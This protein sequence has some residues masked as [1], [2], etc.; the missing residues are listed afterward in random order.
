[1]GGKARAQKLTPEQ[2]TESARRAV[3]A[4][5]AKT[6]RLV[7]EINEGSRALLKRSKAA[8]RRLAQR[9]RKTP[10]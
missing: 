2:R 1:M 9:K 5:W 10:R 7:E 4:R 8:E 3:Q 6:K